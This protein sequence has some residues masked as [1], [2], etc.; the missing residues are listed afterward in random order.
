MSGST[1]VAEEFVEFWSERR[2]CMLASP[3]PDGSIHLVPVGVT[4]DAERRVARVI[5]DGGSYKARNLAAHPGVR[6][7]VSQVEG[8]RW[9]TL[10]GAARV[11]RDPGAVAE[12]VRRY[13]ER[14]RRPRENPER[15]VIEIAVDRVLGNVRPGG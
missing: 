14:Y 6:V 1:V 8:R 10:E 7:S 15:V 4:Y 13:A 2:L 12:A 9:S 3:R 11:S 5:S